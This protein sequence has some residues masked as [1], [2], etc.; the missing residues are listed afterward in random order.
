MAHTD[1]AT[2]L[3]LHNV[4]SDLVGE[5]FVTAPMAPVLGQIWRMHEQRVY[6]PFFL[7][8]LFALSRRDQERVKALSRRPGVSVIHPGTPP[9]IVLNSGA[10]VEP[11]LV[12]SGTFD[13]KPK[14]RDVNR[15]AD[16]YGAAGNGNRP[17]IMV[18]P[19]FDPELANKLG[20][21]PAVVEFDS[22]IRFGLITDRF[23]AGHKLKTSAYLMNNCVVLSYSDVAHDF[24]FAP[25]SDL[26]IRHVHSIEEI[27]A[28]IAD[29]SKMPVE[30]VRDRLAVC[31]NE[32]ASLFSWK[33]QANVL[34]AELT[35]ALAAKRRR[36][37]AFR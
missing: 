9:P 33:K 6:R 22:A 18:K 4:T 2:A 25:F 13:W 27:L 11:E 15:F 21:T 28:I 12:L 26:F 10:K 24:A 19:G 32:I 20:A 3:V 36:R 35:A 14:R 8:V 5:V 30:V 7:D 29:F 34:E 31:K 16:A 23:V 1:T 17:P 37:T